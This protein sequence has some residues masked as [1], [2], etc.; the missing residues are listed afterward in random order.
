MVGTRLGG[1]QNRP[2][3]SVTGTSQSWSLLAHAQSP[4]VV[5]AHFLSQQE[6]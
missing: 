3:Q 6:H 5:P 2:S 4:L 1:S